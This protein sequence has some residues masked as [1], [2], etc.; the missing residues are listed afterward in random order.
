LET[1]SPFDIFKIEMSLLGSVQIGN[2]IDS[3]LR[4]SQRLK[5]STYDRVYREFET[6]HDALG[7][8][9]QNPVSRAW[10]RMFDLINRVFSPLTRIEVSIRIKPL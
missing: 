5:S 3:G 1:L 4:F 8:R 6:P 2:V 9:Y 10:N 7:N